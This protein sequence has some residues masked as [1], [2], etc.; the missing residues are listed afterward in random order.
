MSIRFIGPDE[1]ESTGNKQSRSHAKAGQTVRRG[2]RRTASHSEQED[3]A[4][5]SYDLGRL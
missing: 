5:S 4:Y 1:L 3:A 2:K